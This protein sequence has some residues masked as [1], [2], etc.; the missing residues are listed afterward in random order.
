MKEYEA[1]WRNPKQTSVMWIGLYFAMLS[2]TMVSYEMSDDEPPE[3]KGISPSISDLYRLR[4]AQCLM[5]GDISKC[6]PY[7]L[8]ALVFYTMSE[9]ARKFQNEPRV[10]MMVGLLTRV[11][12]QM[13]YHRSD[14]YHLFCFAC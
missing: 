6:A 10:W 2:Q 14:S 1:Y 8:E 5:I 3:Y 4:V 12:L 9:W 7:T 11:A 13:G